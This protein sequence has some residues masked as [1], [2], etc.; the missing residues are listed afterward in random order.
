MS[1]ITT[2]TF[3]RYQ[4]LASKL[5]AFVMMQFAHRD[6]AKTVGLSFYKL[7]GTG[8]GNG[9]NPYPD[10]GTYALLQVWDNEQDADVFFESSRLFKRYKAKSTDQWRIYMRAIKAEGKWSGSNPFEL[11]S[12]D[13]RI[14]FL[15]IITRATIKKKLLR[16]FWKYVPISEK[17]L[18]RSTGLLHT[19]GIGEVP[20]LQMATFSIW[21]SEEEL[22]TFA[23]RSKEHSKAIALTRELN[24]YSEEL[25]SRFQP[26]RSEG[27]WL[28]RNMLPE[29]QDLK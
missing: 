26:Y 5:W 6:L 20:F 3:F 9:F 21:S 27:T 8:R 10:W 16:K 18:E 14:P 22:K 28:G 11:S 24:W 1:Q 17:P 23:Y 15:A 7:L 4:S 19:K 25:F 2:I 29:L 12:P 13:E